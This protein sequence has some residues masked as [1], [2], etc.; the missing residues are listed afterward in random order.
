M[1]PLRDIAVDVDLDQSAQI[2]SWLR[3]RGRHPE[4]GPDP[5][6]CRI[7]YLVKRASRFEIDMLR[8][9]GGLVTRDDE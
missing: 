4:L 3:A 5:P 7:R 1:E 2:E 6:Q 8:S 9:L